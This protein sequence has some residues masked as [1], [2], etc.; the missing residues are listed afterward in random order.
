MAFADLRKRTTK[1]SDEDQWKLGSNSSSYQKQK[2]KN[3]YNGIYVFPT[4]VVG[5][6]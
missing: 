3:W 5:G 1:C 6:T 4:C 2:K